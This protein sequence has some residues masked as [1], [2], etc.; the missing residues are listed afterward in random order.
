M[1]HKIFVSACLVGKECSYDGRARTSSGVRKLAE[2]FGCVAVCP[3][4]EGGL[5][6]P[7]DMHEISGGT[8]DDVLDGKAKLV[9]PR[10][11]DHT[12]H[13]ISGARKALRIARENGVKIAVMKAR[14]PSCGRGRIYSGRF[15][16]S[17]KDGHGVTAALFAR[18][19]IKVYTEEESDEA[20][21]QLTLLKK[22]QQVL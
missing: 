20:R 7:R 3:E 17:L 9:T 15:D 21:R 19:G 2:D 5:S 16:R 22:R 8:G 14:S 6:C 18:S 11:E 1:S 12:E 10:G 13:F 4:L